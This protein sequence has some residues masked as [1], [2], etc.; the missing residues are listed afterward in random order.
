MAKKVSKK[1]H[2]HEPK[3]SKDAIE[4]LEHFFR[5]HPP[6]YFNRNLRSLVVDWMEC[7]NT[8]A[9]IFQDELLSQLN[10]LFPVLDHI[11]DEGIFDSEDYEI[12]WGHKPEPES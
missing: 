3:L 6:K 7:N 10:S 9:P 8:G 1:S 4:N 2:E 5:C 11:E 12:N